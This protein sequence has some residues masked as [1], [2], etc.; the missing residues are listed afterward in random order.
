M[1]IRDERAAG[2][3]SLWFRG[4]A[5]SGWK[6]VPSLLRS[7]MKVSEASLL[8]R[9]KQS[10]AM[11]ATKSPSNS[12]DWI[13]LMQHYGV[14]TR[15]L[16][17]S[18]NPL[19]AMYF[20]LEGHEGTEPAS[21]W[22]LRPSALNKYSGIDDQDEADYIPSFD[23]DVVKS[24]STEQVRTDTRL[25]L[26]PIATIATRNSP[27]IQAQ[28]GTFT[29]H[30]NLSIPIEDVGDGKHCKKF[31]IPAE[32]VSTLKEELDLLGLNRFSLFPEMESIGVML[33]GMM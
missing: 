24:Y 10:A 29:I 3:G 17:W 23:D 20:A 25:K 14:A 31:I 19:V 16:D 12:F 6:L 9:F 27:R 32:K 8:A 5:N 30:H 26:R 15:L 4:H 11:L 7:A 22:M 13:F 21:L 28:L 2:T 1:C 33:K 18:E